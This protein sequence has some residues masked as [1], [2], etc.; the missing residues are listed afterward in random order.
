[1]KFIKLFIVLSIIT[2]IS[3][4]TYQKDKRNFIVNDFSTSRID[5]LKPYDNKSYTQFYIKI[6]GYVNDSIKI[7]RKGYYDIILVGKLDTII[8]GDYY[9]KEE[10]VFVFNPFHA[11]EGKLEIEYSL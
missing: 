8:N 5:T 1:M 11:K 10:I 4:I 2:F 6:N 7:Q 9:G 3:C